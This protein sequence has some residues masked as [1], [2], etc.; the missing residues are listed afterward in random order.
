MYALASWSDERW[1][2]Q[3]IN[4][5]QKQYINKAGVKKIIHKLKIKRET[6]YKKAELLPTFQ[7]RVKQTILKQP[8]SPQN[9]KKQIYVNNLPAYQ[10]WQQQQGPWI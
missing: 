7:Q 4:L 10:T 3:Q 5:K 2:L 8:S 1:P 9:K 6:K